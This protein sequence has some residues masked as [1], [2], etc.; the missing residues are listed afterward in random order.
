MR[1]PLKHFIFFAGI[2]SASFALAVSASHAQALAT[3]S[4]LDST[5]VAPGQAASTSEKKALVARILKVQ[6]RSIESM[7]RALSEQGFLL[8][9]QRMNAG[10][11]Y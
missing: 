4:S 6:Q 10:Y 2:F 9:S 11:L 5:S 7:G 3:P 1:K 8:L